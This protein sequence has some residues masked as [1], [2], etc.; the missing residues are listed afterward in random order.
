MTAAGPA[1]T[2]RRRRHSKGKGKG[3]GKG[4]RRI[5]REGQKV[6]RSEGGERCPAFEKWEDDNPIL[7]GVIIMIIIMILSVYCSVHT[8]S[9]QS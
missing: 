1:V 2:E 9:P 8:T 5:C 6:R 7:Y 3:K 4:K